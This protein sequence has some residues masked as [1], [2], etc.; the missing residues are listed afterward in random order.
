[1]EESA[2]QQFCFEIYWPLKAS[3]FF[4]DKSKSTL[5][6]FYLGSKLM[7]W[8]SVMCV[9]GIQSAS[10]I[11]VKTTCQIYVVPLLFATLVLKISLFFSILVIYI[12]IT[13]SFCISTKPFSQQCWTTRVIA[14]ILFDKFATENKMA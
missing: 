1:M 14:W 3:T 12:D 6:L 7:L 9:L 10:K 4:D 11:K 2:A 13:I 5:F 8:V